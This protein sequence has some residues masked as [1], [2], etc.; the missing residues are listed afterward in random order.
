MD[1]ATTS[2]CVW[3]AVFLVLAWPVGGFAW[4]A[5]YHGAGTASFT[6]QIP[7][8]YGV[9][10]NGQFSGPV[11]VDYTAG[12]LTFVSSGLVTTVGQVTQG[13]G[14]NNPPLVTNVMGQPVALGGSVH[15]FGPV[16]GD[17]LTMQPT[18]PGFGSPVYSQLQPFGPIS[19]QGFTIAGTANDLVSGQASIY[20]NF[21]S[22]PF[23]LQYTAI[24]H[25]ELHPIVVPPWCAGDVNCDGRVSFADIDPFVARL[26]CTGGLPDC[27][28]PCPWENADVNRDGR[29]SF[30]DIDPFVGAL[31]TACP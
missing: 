29:V 2:R 7:A 20:I 14:Y 25:L 9:S 12:V 8:N 13:Q 3:G 26:G 21:Q 30:A 27:S 15:P 23:N 4:Q 18:W 31:G 28:D 10:G 5:T 16:S 19:F 6:W 22:N 17:A 11:T 24:G 1:R